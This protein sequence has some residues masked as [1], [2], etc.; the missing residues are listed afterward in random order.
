MYFVRVLAATGKKNPKLRVVCAMC[1]SKF[2]EGFTEAVRAIYRA[3]TGSSDM[4]QLL[5]ED[6]CAATI[7]VDEY[8][9]Y[10][11]DEEVADEIAVQLEQSRAG[12]H[13]A[14]LNCST[15]GTRH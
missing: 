1:Y 13:F 2:R 10:P 11:S 3:I 6:G 12:K 15:P 9:D 4:G 14:I 5:T 8:Y 7:E